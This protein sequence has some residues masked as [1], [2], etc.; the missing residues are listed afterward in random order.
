VKLQE[1]QQVVG[2]QI[3]LAII[4]VA[5]LTASYSTAQPIPSR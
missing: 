5:S 2:L 1:I 4:V 3:C